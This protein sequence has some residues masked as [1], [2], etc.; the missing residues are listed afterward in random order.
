MKNLSVKVLTKEESEINK[1]KNFSV[2][3]HMGETLSSLDLTNRT[4]KNAISVNIQDFLCNF[5]LTACKLNKKEYL[6]NLRII[7][8]KLDYLGYLEISD[9]VHSQ[10]GLPLIKELSDVVKSILPEK[11]IDQINRQNLKSIVPEELDFTHANDFIN[12]LLVAP[13]NKQQIDSFIAVKL[14]AKQRN[15]AMRGIVFDLTFNDMKRLFKRKYCYYSGVEMNLTEGKKRITLDRKDCT[16]GY[17]KDNVVAC[18]E[19]ANEMK[20]SLVE[21][22]ELF[23]NSDLTPEQQKQLMSSL[24]KLM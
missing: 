20:N 3:K 5:Y 21:N 14:L 16:K 17:T 10:T 23:N 18:C 19:F 1:L 9:R 11:N 6:N 4:T 8:E 15:C 22:R 24:I 2:E 12:K 13:T 7:I